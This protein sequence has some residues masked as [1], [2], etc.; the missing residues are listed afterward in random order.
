MNQAHVKPLI[1]LIGYFL[2]IAS[3]AV[4]AQPAL[5][6]HQAYGGESRE[7][8]WDLIQ[9]EEGGYL[10]GGRTYIYDDSRDNFFCVKTDERGR[11]IWTYNE[12]GEESDGC[13]A[14]LQI[15]GEFYLLAG[16]TFVSF[17]EGYN[18]WLIKLDE[19]GEE[20]WSR[21]YNDNGLVFFSSLIQSGDG[22][23]VL[24]GYTSNDAALLKMDED[25]E[26]IWSRTYGGDASDAFSSVIQ[27][28]DDGYAAAG[29]TRSFDVQGV[30]AYF[31][32]TDEEGEEEWYLTFGDEIRDSFSSIIQTEDGGYALGGS[33]N[34]E[35]GINTN[36]DFVLVR[37]DSEGEIL[38][39]R[40]YGGRRPEYFDDMLQTLDGGFILAG[41]TFSFGAGSDDFYLVRINSTGD[42]LWSNTYGGRHAERVLGAIIQ[43]EDLGY[44]IGGSSSSYNEDGRNLEDFWLVKTGPEPLMLLSFTDS[45]F[46][47][48]G[49]LT[50]DLDF[51]LEHIIPV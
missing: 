31:V 35:P 36:P 25:G 30:D 18:G 12:G 43:T 1:T 10:L 7:S 40:T 3:L 26:V 14:V 4:Y 5:Q 51:L 19:D 45:S 9:T 49:E 23:L 15:D 34:V 38:W 6:W 42:E 41:T 28:N 16:Y 32:K 46:V 50:Y 37:T 8:C 2:L 22:N 47:E 33:I 24:S 39:T 27:T 20:V 17:D 21:T 13:I 11:E 29:E 48:D 44:A